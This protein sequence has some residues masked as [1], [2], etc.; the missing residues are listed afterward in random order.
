MLH[1]CGYF[2]VSI[3]KGVTDKLHLGKRENCEG[4]ISRQINFL[5]FSK[6]CTMWSHLILLRDNLP[7][8]KV[9]RSTFII[10]HFSILPAIKWNAKAF[11]Y[12]V[13]DFSQP[14]HQKH[15]CYQK[16]SLSIW[17]QDCHGG[18]FLAFKANKQAFHS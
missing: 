9:N 18:F 4:H 5:C 7:Q 12:R 10:C 8:T 16:C 3:F 13:R 14:K 1:C 6:S 2:Q 11:L 15:P 17:F